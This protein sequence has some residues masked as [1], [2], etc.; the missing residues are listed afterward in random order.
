M[1][2]SEAQIDA[3]EHRE[4]RS[5]RG[6]EHSHDRREGK[7]NNMQVHNSNQNPNNYWATLKL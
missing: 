6:L 1:P 4:A 5:C 3:N 7:G 2:V